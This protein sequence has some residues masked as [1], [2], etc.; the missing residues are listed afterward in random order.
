MQLRKRV[1]SLAC[2]GE[3]I[4]GLAHSRQNGWPRKMRERVYGARQ[5]VVTINLHDPYADLYS[6]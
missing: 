2:P 1:R 5:L 3:V 6:Q 4:D